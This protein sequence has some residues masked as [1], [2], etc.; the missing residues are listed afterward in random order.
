MV[1]AICR[2]EQTIYSK[3]RPGRQVGRALSPDLFACSTDP[4]SP[5]NAACAR[6]G[7]IYECVE[8][9]GRLGSL[10]VSTLFMREI[11]LF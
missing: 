4:L 9:E 10:N 6:I 7:M 5:R 2:H 11:F 1:V 3:L 8:K